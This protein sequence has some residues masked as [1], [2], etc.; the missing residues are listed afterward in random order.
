MEAVERPWFSF[1]WWSFFVHLS[2]GKV[3]V[4]L[5]A[6]LP[7]AVKVILGGA[8]TN[9]ELLMLPHDWRGLSSGQSI[10]TS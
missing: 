6:S 7:N 3:T 9:E 4:Q 5:M 10:P 1:P 8:L 2:S